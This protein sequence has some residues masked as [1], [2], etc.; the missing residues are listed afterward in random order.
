MRTCPIVVSP[1]LLEQDTGPTGCVEILPERLIFPDHV[2]REETH[3][4]AFV[5]SCHTA[6]RRAPFPESSI[7]VVRRKNS[8][9]SLSCNPYFR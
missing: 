9:V 1:T 6:C 8:S 3:V 5:F 4:R 2:E 7:R